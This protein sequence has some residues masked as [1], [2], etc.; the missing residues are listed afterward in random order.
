VISDSNASDIVIM[1]KKSRMIDN[2][3]DD[4]VCSDES[5]SVRLPEFSLVNE[6]CDNCCPTNFN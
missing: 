1:R 4:D 5:D 2:S 3:A 6:N